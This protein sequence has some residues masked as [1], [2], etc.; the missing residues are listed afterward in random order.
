MHIDH[1]HQ[2]KML[3]SYNLLE[4]KHNIIKNQNYMSAES[5]VINSQQRTTNTRGKLITTIID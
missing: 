2:W 4:R 5:T 3:Y 1:T